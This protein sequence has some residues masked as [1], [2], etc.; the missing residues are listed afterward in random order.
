[1]IY[2]EKNINFSPFAHEGRAVK[3]VDGIIRVTIVVELDEG[4]SVLE[5]DILDPAKSVEELLDVSLAS[6]VG[7]APYV[8]SGR[9]PRR[10]GETGK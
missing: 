6:A 9:H 1:M 2:R 3:V 5:G 4:E 8:D 10:N 7:N